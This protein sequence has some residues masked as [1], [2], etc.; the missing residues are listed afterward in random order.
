MSLLVWV[1]QVWWIEECAR[2]EFLSEKI[3][4][5]QSRSKFS[6]AQKRIFFWRVFWTVEVSSLCFEIWA[7][8]RLLIITWYSIYITWYLDPFYTK[9]LARHAMIDE[10][11]S[12]TLVKSFYPSLTSFFCTETQS[13]R[14]STFLHR[15]SVSSTYI[16]LRLFHVFSSSSIWH[17]RSFWMQTQKHGF[18]NVM[19]TRHSWWNM[20]F[21]DQG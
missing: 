9:L 4:L 10:D 21:C 3:T 19:R 7:N 5:S 8:K 20:S 14:S 16:C 15:N 11:S 17:F 13:G 6:F 18:R 12:Q 1:D 2:K